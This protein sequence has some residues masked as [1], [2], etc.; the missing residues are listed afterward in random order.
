M[1]F[2]KGLYKDSALIDQPQSTHRDALNMVMNLD[3]GSIS[4]EYGNTPTKSTELI[5]ATIPKVLGPNRQERKINGSI[6]LPDNKF[7]V[8]YSQRYYNTSNKKSASFIY[9]FDPEGDVMT[10]LFA[11]SGDSQSEFYNKFAGDL[12][13][14]TEYPIT[15][16]ARVAANG[17]IIVYF[18]DNYK[19]VKIDPITKIE[20]IDSYN[21]PRVFNVTKQLN[22]IN[23]GGA[24]TNLYISAPTKFLTST[25][26][27]DY[28]N[29]FLTTKKIPQIKNHS[30]IKGGIL[31]SGAYYLCLAYANDEYT[32]TNIYTVSQPVY[33]LKVLI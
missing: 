14:S 5:N 20:Y 19:D 27:V 25:K 32:E 15:G 13:F 4:T 1:K 16:E 7:I 11:T 10:L 31:E 2:L 24:V 9:L 26:H 3:K 8:F 30:L 22:V 23:N 6:L 28:L 17:D 29:L 33:I 21:P 18:T 12:N